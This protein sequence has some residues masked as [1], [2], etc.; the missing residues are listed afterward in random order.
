M[1]AKAPFGWW[2]ADVKNQMFRY[3]LVVA[4]KMGAK[5]GLVLVIMVS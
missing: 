1:G 3:S 4:N 5:L 2:S